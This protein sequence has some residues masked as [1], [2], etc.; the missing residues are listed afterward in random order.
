METY[1]GIF[2]YV[3]KTFITCQESLQETYKKDEN[4][5]KSVKM[6]I[7][8]NREKDFFY[9]ESN[10]QVEGNLHGGNTPFTISIQTKW[11]KEMMLRHDH[12]S[13][14]F[15]IVTFRTNDKKVTISLYFRDTL[16]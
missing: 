15:I 2:F 6:W 11:Q 1:Q 16:F 12:E 9:Q 14:V 4:D 7:I 3:S 10:V 13:G 8:E 5:V